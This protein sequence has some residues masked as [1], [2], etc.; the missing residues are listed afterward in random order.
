MP[1]PISFAEMG[2]FLLDEARA[3]TLDILNNLAGR[4]FR[5]TRNMKVNMIMTNVTIQDCYIPC[6]AYL[7]D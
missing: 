3:A 5:W 6:F 2:K 1:S 4:N 7:A